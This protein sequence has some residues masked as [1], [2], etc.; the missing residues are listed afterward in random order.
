MQH[1]KK[2]TI[3]ELS[4]LF[5]LIALSLTVSRQFKHDQYTAYHDEAAFYGIQI[6]DTLPSETTFTA[7]DDSSFWG[8]P[9]FKQ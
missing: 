6:E 1:L 5:C 4:L 7:S 8:I 2:R 3:I 9:E